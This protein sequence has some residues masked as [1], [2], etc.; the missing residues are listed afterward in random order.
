MRGLGFG[1]FEVRGFAVPGFWFGV[2]S[3][4]FR[5]SGF[6]FGFSRIWVSRLVFMDSGWVFRIL[7]VLGFDSG[8]EVP[9]FTF[10]VSPFWVSGSVL[11][12]LGFSSSSFRV[13]D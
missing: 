4:G 11:R 1:V 6:G 12:G 2:S 8:F 3:F 7:E 5:G 13:S 9:G 10:G